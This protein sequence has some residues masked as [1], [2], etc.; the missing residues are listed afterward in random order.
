MENIYQSQPAKIIKVKNETPKVKHFVLK[1]LNKKLQKEFYCLPGQF[2]EVSL[3]GFGEAPLTPS[4]AFQDKDYFELSIRA[5]GQLTNKLY[6]LKDKDEVLVRGPYG[7]GFP[8]IKETET[9]LVAG[10][11]GIIPLRSL[12]LTQ[13]KKNLGSK[14]TVF[15]GA[16][17]AGDFLFADEF[18][19]WRKAGVKLY[20]TIDK[21]CS[22]WEGCV[23]AVTILFDKVFKISGQFAIL[24]GP[25]LMYKFVLEKLHQYGFKDENIYLSLERRIHCGVGVCQ[26]CAIG[27]KY[28]CKDGPVFKYK[29]I[30]DIDGV[31]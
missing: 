17:T 30:K 4:S 18:K 2:V 28:V 29:E 15:Y 31:I 20:L 11:L 6:Q 16:K 19:E 13:I 10:G 22:D 21:E 12:I 8:E 24:C 26:H 1:F 23:G 27:S 7:N 25:P 3:P 14:L 9:L 5:V